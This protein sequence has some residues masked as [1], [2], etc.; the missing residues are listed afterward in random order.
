MQPA[1]VCDWDDRAEGWRLGHPRDGS[2]LVQRVAS[3]CTTANE[4]LSGRDTRI[5]TEG[6]LEEARS[7]MTD[8]RASRPALNVPHKQLLSGDAPT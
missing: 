3:N 2:I 8:T 4:F 6:L 1:D 5:A 7:G